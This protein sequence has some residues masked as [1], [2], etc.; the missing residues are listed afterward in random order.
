MDPYFIKSK[1]VNFISYLLN[2]L[3]NII[4]ARAPIGVKNAPTL[5][6]I[7]LANIAL[8]YSPLLKAVG[9]LENKMLIGMLFITLD[10]RYDETPYVKITGP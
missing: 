4:P 5:L 2:K 9:T 6:P 10:K 7:I 1:K 8:K 3:E